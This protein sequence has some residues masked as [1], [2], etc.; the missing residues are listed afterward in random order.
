MLPRVPERAISELQLGFSVESNAELVFR[1]YYRKVV[2]Y[3]R[4]KGIRTI[5]VWILLKK[6]S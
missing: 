1:G 2:S 3:F 5:S 6:C 4:S